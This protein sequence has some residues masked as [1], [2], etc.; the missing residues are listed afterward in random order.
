MFHGNSQ[1]SPQLR[2]LCLSVFD[3]EVGPEEEFSIATASTG[4]KACPS[5]I[6]ISNIHFRWLSLDW[7]N[8][9]RVTFYRNT[10]YLD[11]CV[12]LLREAPAL[13]NLVLVDVSDPEDTEDW[14]EDAWPQYPIIHHGLERFRFQGYKGHELGRF[15]NSFAFPGLKNLELYNITDP[16]LTT[17]LISLFKRSPM[18]HFTNLKVL[19]P[20]NDDYTTLVELLKAVPFLEHFDIPNSLSIENVMKIL[21]VL[22]HSAV[23]VDNDDDEIEPFDSFLPNLQSISYSESMFGESILDHPLFWLI[24]SHING[25]PEEIIHWTPNATGRRPLKHISISC[26]RSSLTEDSAICTDVFIVK[27]LIDLIAAGVRFE[28]ED[29]TVDVIKASMSF[30]GLAS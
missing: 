29:G 5:D 28:I 2:K 9:D 26:F 3:V 11:D 17:Y 22:A 15:F 13:R 30:H 27:H 25:P 18:P 16:S 21:E 4:A 23:I 7:K 20:A 8:L 6:Q 24:I 10:I 1:G 12:V 14:R 19:P